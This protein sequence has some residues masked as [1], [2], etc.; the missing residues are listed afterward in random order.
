MIKKIV[1]GIVLFGSLIHAD[2]QNVATMANVK[3]SLEALI[4]AYY[5]MEQKQ[6]KYQN[7]LDDTNQSIS[8]KV[9]EMSD[10][11]ES[12]QRSASKQQAQL[13][14]SVQ[15]LQQNIYNGALIMKCSDSDREDTIIKNFISE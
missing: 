11:I 7:V 14:K 6:A 5:K 4:D 12:L 2:S 3:N 10:A 9:F 13:E 1:I 15:H 8:K